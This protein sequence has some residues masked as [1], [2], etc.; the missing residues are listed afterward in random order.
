MFAFTSPGIQTPGAAA[1]D[2]GLDA[3]DSSASTGLRGTVEGSSGSP[4]SSTAATEESADSATLSDSNLISASSGSYS[5]TPDSS[6]SSYASDAAAALEAPSSAEGGSWPE[7]SPPLSAGASEAPSLPPSKTRLGFG[8]SQQSAGTP[9]SA[10]ASEAESPASAGLMLEEMVTAEVT[11]PSTRRFSPAPPATAASAAVARP[12]QASAHGDTHAPPAWP[13]AALAE[14]VGSCSAYDSSAYAVSP[15]SD[16]AVGPA[17]GSP[18]MALPGTTSPASAES[19]ATPVPPVSPSPPVASFGQWIA[20][21][22]AWTLWEGASDINC[23]EA[24]LAAGATVVAAGAHVPASWLMLIP[25]NGYDLP[26]CSNPAAVHMIM[27]AFV[28][29]KTMSGRR[30]PRQ[31][32]VERV[33]SIAA[34]HKSRLRAPSCAAAPAGFRD[35]P[36]SHWAV[37]AAAGRAGGFVAA[38]FSDSP[39]QTPSAWSVPWAEN[40]DLSAAATGPLPL[41]ELESS[42]CVSATPPRA[43]DAASDASAPGSHS[44][45][46][47][48]VAGGPPAWDGAAD[49]AVPATPGSSA[50]GAVV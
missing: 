27:P 17:F 50:P 3:Q 22:G 32:H 41:E 47:S 2:T 31:S 9:D 12:H 30:Y 28:S 21:T 14:A 16:A 15:A 13:L 5:C 23:D 18:V 24:Q 25:R 19:P 20:A 43:P 10:S 11:T 48:S 37:P 38:L 35:T 39:L 33:C 45:R 44:A 42:S 34:A 1:A 49:A 36:G 29:S 6:F 4:A 46:G 40:L 7:V 8:V 26:N